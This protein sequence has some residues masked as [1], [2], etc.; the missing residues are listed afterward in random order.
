MSA[1]Q[2]EFNVYVLGLAM[3]IYL[4]LVKNV[5]QAFSSLKETLKHMRLENI[6]KNTTNISV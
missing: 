3:L 6:D 5:E 1:L 2:T 4:E